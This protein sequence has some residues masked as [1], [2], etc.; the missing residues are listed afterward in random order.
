MVEKLPDYGLNKIKFVK[1]Q[2]FWFSKYFTN[3]LENHKIWEFFIFFFIY[4]FVILILNFNIRPRLKHMTLHFFKLKKV[5]NEM[6]KFEA[7]Y[8]PNGTT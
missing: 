2:F 5:Q 7:I 8:R 4:S 6:I 3:Y 1:P